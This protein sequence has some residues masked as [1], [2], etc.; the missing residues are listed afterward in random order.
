MAP[1]DADSEDEAES[2]VSATRTRAADSRNIH[3]GGKKRMSLLTGECYDV[4]RLEER[5]NGYFDLGC[6]NEPWA[7]DEAIGRSS[8]RRHFF[9][10]AARWGSLLQQVVLERERAGVQN[11]IVGLIKLMTENTRRSEVAPSDPM[12][13]EMEVDE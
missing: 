7:N 9:P 11:G 12:E 10:G 6:G 3:R 8:T 1:S 2:D 4:P 5:E 13:E